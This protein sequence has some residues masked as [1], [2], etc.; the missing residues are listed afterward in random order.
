[1]RTMCVASS[2]GDAF[3]IATAIGASI[4]G[5]DY[6]NRFLGIPISVMHHPDGRVENFMH[7]GGVG[8]AK[9]GVL[10]VNDLGSRFVNEAAPYND[11][12]HQMVEGQVATA[13]WIFDHNHFA[14]YGAGMLLPPVWAR[15]T[16]K[17]LNACYLFRSKT[18]AGLAEQLRLPVDQF[19]KSVLRYNELARA[20]VDT[21]FGKGDNIY[22]RSTGDANH[23]PNPNMGP[24]KK[25]PYYA[26]PFKPGNL[27]TYLGLD[28]DF[29]A[30][31]KDGDGRVI[32]GLYAC[33]LDA[34]SIFSGCYP[35]GGSSIGPSMVFGYIE[36]RHMLCKSQSELA[37]AGERQVA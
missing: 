37:G 31:V 23:Y 20:G 32:D 3:R 4:K 26:V 11:F 19:T 2:D 36:G 9:P 18:L 17:Y 7:T 29:N 16:R 25:A 8:R 12:V 22:D 13:Y 30:R 33:G 14:R 34:A 24:L 1:M 35:G 5:E 28:T 6:F 15:S 21:D 10:A 27:G